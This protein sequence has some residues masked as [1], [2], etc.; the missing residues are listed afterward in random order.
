M[1]KAKTIG[2][3]ELYVAGLL[4]DDR[5]SGRIEYAVPTWVKGLKK[6][7]L[8]PNIN[9]TSY[10]A[11]NMLEDVIGG[12]TGAQL[13]VVTSTLSLKEI[14]LLRGMDPPSGASVLEDYN[15]KTDFVAVGYRRLMS[16]HTAEGRAR[17]RY[18]WL[19]KAK[20]D[21]PEENSETREENTTVQDDTLAGDLLPLQAFSKTGKA[22]AKFTYDN[23]EDNP[24]PEIE[25][26]FFKRVWGYPGM[27]ETEFAAWIK[28][29]EQEGDGGETP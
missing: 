17:A 27:G 6:L 25:E 9:N 4:E 21:P 16:G 8:K 3:S 23:W 29:Q 1:G 18:V 26:N 22:Y 19:F 14:A 15:A 10:Y 11:D 5:E 13:S 7:G 2:V 28:E 12:Q 24:S 20:L